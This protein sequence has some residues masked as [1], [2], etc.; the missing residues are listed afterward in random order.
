M[1]RHDMGCVRMVMNTYSGGHIPAVPLPTLIG[2]W[3][4]KKEDQCAGDFVRILTGYII[5][6]DIKIWESCW[7]R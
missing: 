5:I 1:T 3:Y 6:V 7:T 4:G 2:S